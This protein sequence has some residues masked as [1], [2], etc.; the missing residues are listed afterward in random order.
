[1]IG[2]KIPGTYDSSIGDLVLTYVGIKKDTKDEKKEGL[3]DSESCALRLFDI[4]GRCS[5]E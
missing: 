3:D 4:V 2:T 5:E 1:M